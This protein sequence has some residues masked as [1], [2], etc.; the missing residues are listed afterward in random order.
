M[1]DWIELSPYWVTEDRLV[2]ADRF[3]LWGFVLVTSTDGGSIT[4]YNQRSA[5]AADTMGTYKA[6]ANSPLSVMF[7]RGVSCE[8]GLYVDVGSNVTGVL[9]IGRP[10][11]EPPA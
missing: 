2:S 3:E 8:R 10:I 4:L 11:F 1:L 9:I 7:P 5:E 6:L